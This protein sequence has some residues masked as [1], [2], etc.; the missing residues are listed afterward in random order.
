MKY[1]DFV[2]VF[3][4][5]SFQIVQLVSSRNDVQKYDHD[6][7]ENNVWWKNTIIYQIYPRSFKDF[8]GNGIG[9]IKGIE[10]NLNYFKYI[11]VG[12]VWIS[13]IYKSPMKDFGYDI[14]DFK[15][16]DPIFGTIDDFKSL[17]STAH[18]MG[19]KIIMD[20]VPNHSSDEHDWFQKSVRREEPYTDYYVWVDPKGFDDNGDPIPPS[21]WVSHF[22]FSAWQFVEERGQFYLH[23]YLPQQPDLNYRNPLVLEEMKDVL[24][25]WLDLGVDGFRMDAVVTIWEDDRWLDEPP[26]GD[27]N[28]ADENDWLYYD[29]IYTINLPETRNILKEFYETIKSYGDDKLSV[30]EANV[31]KLEDFLEYYKSCDFPF[32]FN[33]PNSWGSP[34]NSTPPYPLIASEVKDQIDEWI[35]KTPEGKIANWVLGSHDTSRV[36]NRYGRKYVD[37]LNV[38]ALTLPGTVITY[39][40]EEIGMSNNLNISFFETQDPRGCNCGPERYMECSRD[41]ER[42]PYQWNSEDQ[43]AG[44]S[45][46]TSA[47][48]WLPINSNYKK[49]DEDKEGDCGINFQDEN[50]KVSSH[51]LNY[52]DVSFERFN[53]RFDGEF[54]AKVKME[55]VLAFAICMTPFP[56]ISPCRVTMSN[57]GEEVITVDIYKDFNLL[58]EEGQV[59]LSTER[60]NNP[61]N[62]FVDLRSITL[63]PYETLVLCLE[64]SQI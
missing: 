2:V 52:R 63:V 48:T 60:E 37:A 21:N 24:R 49:C 6:G 3:W 47:E 1:W 16:I 9:D 17:I 33:F 64:C 18:G 62:S 44:F 58:A 36:A 29:H 50:H 57:F 23:Q 41:P 42:T 40:G 28:A 27:P 15:D 11:H 30:L 25:F 22:R 35:E 46:N 38:M 32:N 43:T 19:L 8:D 7:I 5:S 26:S 56:E 39:Q 14:S 20:F 51:F 53:G 31:P 55:S 10:A 12:G 59:L 34:G 61:P 4:F 13:P 54:S 45:T